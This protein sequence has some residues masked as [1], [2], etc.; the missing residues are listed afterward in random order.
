LMRQQARTAQRETRF[1]CA[2]RGGSGEAALHFGNEGRCR[3]GR[4]C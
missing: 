2:G 4:M 3:R 1:M